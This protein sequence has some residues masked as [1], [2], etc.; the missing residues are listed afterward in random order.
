MTGRLTILAA[1]AL[2]AAAC[3]RE[4]RRFREVPPGASA[5]P[6]VT[7]NDDVQPGPALIDP[8]VANAYE[9][10]AWA[11]S[12]GKRLYDQWNCAGCHS[13]RGGGGMGPPLMDSLWIYGSEPENIFATIVEGRPDGM[14]AFRGRIGN[15][16]V[17]K[18]VAYVRTMAALTPKSVRSGR[19]DDA[20]GSSPNPQ[21]RRRLPPDSMIPAESRP[22]A[23]AP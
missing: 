23:S 14:P 22:P 21:S 6:A 15:D 17:W 8:E 4:E 16:D 5:S 19:T 13:P 1:L 2:L 11:T 7:L 12:E 20:S 10:N 18:L 3:E 9:R